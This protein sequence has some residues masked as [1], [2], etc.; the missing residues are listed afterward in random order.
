MKKCAIYTRVSTS[1][2]AEKEYNSI[3]LWGFDPLES[4]SKQNGLSQVFT[5]RES[6]LFTGEAEG[7]RTLDL[8]RDREAL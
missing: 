5:P 1:M 6:V 3:V 2:Q 7:I 4:S 8:L